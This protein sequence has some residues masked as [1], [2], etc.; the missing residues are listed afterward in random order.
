MEYRLTTSGES[1]PIKD[2]KAGEVIK[3]LKD[4]PYGEAANSAQLEYT[5]DMPEAKQ[6]LEKLVEAGYVHKE[7][8][9]EKKGL[10]FL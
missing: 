2:N 10:R 9:Y 8:E 1:A 6:I 4:L 3:F 7:E 5:L